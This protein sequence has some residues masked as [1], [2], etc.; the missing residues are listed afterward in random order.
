MSKKDFKAR[1]APKLAGASEL[2]LSDPTMPFGKIRA[3]GIDLFRRIE[4]RKDS[5]K[6]F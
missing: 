6:V 3:R 1:R 2:S 4:R 5:V